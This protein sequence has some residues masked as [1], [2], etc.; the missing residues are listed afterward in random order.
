LPVRR[1]PTKLKQLL[2]APFKGKLLASPVNIRLGWKGFS[3]TNTLAYFRKSVNYSRKKILLQAPGKQK[4]VETLSKLAY[5][6]LLQ[7]QFIIMTG[8]L[9]YF[10]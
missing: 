8:D 10:V 9:S 6:K 4:I 1:K 3:R 2:G 7:F 5:L